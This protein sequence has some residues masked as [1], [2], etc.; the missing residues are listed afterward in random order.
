MRAIVAFLLLCSVSFGQCHPFCKISKTSGDTKSSI[1]GAVIGDGVVLTCAHMA[2]SGEVD[3]EFFSSS[4]AVVR[5]GMIVLVDVDRDMA[6]IE[7][8]TDGVDSLEIGSEPESGNVRIVGYPGT[9]WVVTIT[10]SIV[11]VGY[12]QHDEPRLEVDFLAQYGM[13]GSPVLFDGKVI[14]VQSCRG[15]K[16]GCSIC[17]SG[18]QVSAFVER[19]RRGDRIGK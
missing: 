10:G 17:S 6:I 2:Q 14:G 5:H 16:E 1:S 12:Y 9:D 13:S 4:E 18:K 11:D 3:V 7:V 8:S 15:V 19:F